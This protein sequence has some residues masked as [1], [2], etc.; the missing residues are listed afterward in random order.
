MVAKFSIEQ[1][2]G[3][4]GKVQRDERRQMGSTSMKEHELTADL[5]KNQVAIAKK[6]R[7]GKRCEGGR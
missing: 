7:K 1:I 2:L 5:I 4:L 6:R 3:K